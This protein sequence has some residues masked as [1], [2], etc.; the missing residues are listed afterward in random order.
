M[1]DLEHD[2]SAACSR[3]KVSRIFFHILL[4]G[5]FVLFSQNS[6]ELTEKANLCLQTKAFLIMLKL[7][8]SP[9]TK[10]HN[11]VTLKFKYKYT[12]EECLQI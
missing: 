10:S 6:P 4:R 8:A 12:L 5:F 9:Q 2:V 11:T 3:E 7:L 1:Q